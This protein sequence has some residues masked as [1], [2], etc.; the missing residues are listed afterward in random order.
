ML[1][2]WSELESISGGRWLSEPEE[3]DGIAE[4]STDSRTIPR[5]AAFL[6]LS[7]DTFDGHDFI[8]AATDNGALA[9]I[10]SKPVET[11]IPALV[12]EN[13]LRAY[14]QLAT[15]HRQRFDRLTVIGITGSSGKTST[16]EIIAAVM[17]E[18]FGENA[19]L[20]TQGNTNNQIGVPQNLLRLTNE[21]RC[22]VL[23]MGTNYHGEIAILR[24]MVQ[25][26]VA[27]LTNIGPVH[28]EGLGSIEGVAREKSC[29][30]KDADLA[31][32]QRGYLD[33]PIVA[34]ALPGN[35]ATTGFEDDAD[36]RIEYLGSALRESR[37][38]L[39]GFDADPLEIGWQLRG[40]HMVLN[41]A[42]AA[43]I[44]RHLKIPRDTVVAGLSQ[45][46]PTKM[47]MQIV[48]QRGITWINDAYNAN[49][50]SMRALIDWLSELELPGKLVLVLGD[51][52]ELGP[53]SKQL[54]RET[55]EYAVAA[56]PEAT[57]LLYGSEMS[58]QAL[59]LAT[60]DS[61]ESAG[62]WLREHTSAGDTVALKGS[63]GMALER[64]LE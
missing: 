57:L 6:A 41:A 44:A 30:F 32:L 28:L 19:V 15:H 16:K 59:Q 53:D 7:G 62:R 21:H 48:E 29:I 37:F 1:F 35:V 14:Q 46:R 60:A 18:H 49:P 17:R 38:R 8:A 52:L 12:V 5:G 34:D 45:L 43:A 23:E 58:R 31:V 22:A 47:R 39:L 55:I 27:V 42:A 10:V 63:R 64:L 3:A 40:R 20:T 25:P 50:D 9:C 4:I 13:T 33:N 26:D 61:H 2:S 36:I 24:D 54:H 11:S 56:L 51:M